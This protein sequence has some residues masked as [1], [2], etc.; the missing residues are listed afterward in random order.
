MFTAAGCH[1]HPQLHIGFETLQVCAH[2]LDFL[3]VGVLP[4]SE[5]S[6]GE[7]STL[8]F[9]QGNNIPAFLAGIFPPYVLQNLPLKTKWKAR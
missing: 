3:L 6:W 4:S 2:G 7:L 5:K 8:L 1:G 9:L